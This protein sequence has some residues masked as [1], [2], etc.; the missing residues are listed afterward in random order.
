VPVLKP[1]PP[2]LRAALW[3]VGA[4]T[5]WGLNAGMI[6]YAAADVPALQF[7]FLRAL[8]GALLMLP[9][10]VP[11]G[12]SPVPR[13]HIGL[14]LARGGL[15]AAAIASWFV[16]LALMQTGDVI[17]LGF[18]MPLFATILAVLF[19]GERVRLRRGIA[20]GIGLVGALIVIKPG[21]DGFSAVALLPILGAIAV[22]GS[23]AVA[24]RLAQHGEPVLTMVASLGFLTAPV[25][26]IPALFVWQPLGLSIIVQAILLSASSLMGHACMVRALRLEETSALVP[27]EF[28]QLLVAV[29]FGIAVLG[30]W[31]DHWT[32]VGSAVILCAA[33]YIVR[34]EAALAR[35]ARAT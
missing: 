26:L 18:T 20:I 31:P 23:R 25:L 11:A 22:A 4:M 34:R 5:C 13:R 10:L 27:Y 15:E 16:A 14:Y 6:R 21:P 2:A 17:A 29:A 1:L 3:Y 24:R 35:Q 28:S 9:W 12:V 19:L 30:E 32:W 33:V 7:G 8:F